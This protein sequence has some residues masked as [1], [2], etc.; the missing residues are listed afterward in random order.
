MKPLV[1]SPKIDIGEYTY[2]TDPDHAMEFATRNVLYAFGPERLIIG[3]FCAIANGVRFIMNG[4]NHAMTG[5]G[6][7]PFN[8]FGG[9]WTTATAGVFESLPSRGDTVVGNN[10]W[11]GLNAIVLPGVNIGHG[12]VVGAAAV[13]TRDVPPFAVIAG[14]PARVVRKRF[15][16][17][18]IER[19]LELAWWDWP[20]EKITKYARTILTGGVAEL[21]KAAKEA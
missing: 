21:E 11:L 4:G 15:S 3:K 18:E 5:A 7:F 12:A 2:Y 1:N 20:V 8:M 9:D 19:L 17:P 6:T 13:V 16:D 14:N 10:V